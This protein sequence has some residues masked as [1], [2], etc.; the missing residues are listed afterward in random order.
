MANVFNVAE[1]I[2]NRLGTTSA[3]KLEKLCYYSQAWSLVWDEKPLFE[4]KIEA[5]NYGPV[6]PDLYSW[7]RGQF[8]VSV[9][10]ALAQKV[11]T[12]A[13]L[14]QTQKE[15][16]DAVLQTYGQF[17]AQELSDLTHKEEPWCRAMDAR[18]ECGGRNA[19]ITPAMMHEYYSSI[20][21]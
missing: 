16:I 19:E 8:L 21:A 5:W 15:T 9:N 20:P 13:P 14:T 18:C 6:S 2:L 12:E 4:N 17:T 1:Y 11:D 7:H 3:M 10:D